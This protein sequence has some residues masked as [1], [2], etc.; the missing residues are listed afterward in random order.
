MY[1]YAR[2][3]DHIYFYDKQV[4]QAKAS[5]KHTPTQGWRIFGI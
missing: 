2:S 4:A 1:I 3:Y 5:F